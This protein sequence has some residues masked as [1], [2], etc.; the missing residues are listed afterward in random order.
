MKVLFIAPG[1]SIHTIR[2]VNA[3]ADR[4]SKVN[5]YTL[6]PP[7]E[8][9]N[10]N[11]SLKLEE[12][13]SK[14]S[15]ITLARKLRRHFSSGNF[16]VVHVCYASG[17]GTLARLAKIPVNFL[18]VWGSDV[19]DFPRKS[20][21]HHY[22]VRKNL[23]YADTVLSTS[24]SMGKM[25]QSLLDHELEVT[26]IPYGVDTKCFQKNMDMHNANF[27]KFRVGIVKVLDDKYGID[28]FIE[29]A[30][31]ILKCNSD[32]EFVVVGDGPKRDKYIRYA[33]ELGIQ[34]DIKFIGRI[35][36]TELPC[37][38]NSLNCF[39]ALSRLDSES[40]G[41]VAVEAMSCEVPVVL[42]DVS[43]FIEVTA[44]GKFGTIVPRNDPSSAANAILAIYNQ[45][46]FHSQKVRSARHHV[47]MYYDWDQN[48]SQLLEEY[49]KCQKLNSP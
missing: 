23:L 7:I 9:L 45:R 18:S 49:K 12:Y 20:P 48:V 36:N 43:G 34:D 10:S 4:L 16:D 24:V 25:T 41:V 27:S 21:L 8:A 46:K 32:F 13:P 44:K 5:L 47:E 33:Y 19:Y 39:C 40:F 3:L 26:V 6:H 14:L 22:V 1:N 35:N 42:S 15:Y 37:F 31:I 28:T 17:Y 11:V 2:W 29:M 30:S 38:Y